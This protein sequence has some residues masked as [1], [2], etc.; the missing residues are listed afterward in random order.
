MIKRLCLLLLPA[1]CVTLLALTGPRPLRADNASAPIV[2][3]SME[4]FAPFN[5]YNDAG[6]Y[7]GL[8]TEVINAVF[9]SLGIAYEHAPRPWKRALLEFNSGVTDVLFQ[10][11][12]TEERA[13][14][15]HGVKLRNNNQAYY[16][17][18]AS[19][20]EDIASLADL[21]GLTVGTIAGFTYSA[22]FDRAAN[23]EKVVTKTF[24]AHLR[25]LLAGRADVIIANEVTFEHAV[26]QMGLSASFRKLPTYAIQSERWIA[27]QKTPEGIALGNRFKAQLET[28]RAS[29]ALAALRATIN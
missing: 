9:A 24:D 28:M 26:E 7:V 11:T 16:V 18:P 12:P 6:D 1:A 2:I 15:W 10:F 4:S 27:F 22:E 17:T 19:P 29:G 25:I 8:D 21:D 13:V 14:K 20:I 23:F 5:Y 3:G